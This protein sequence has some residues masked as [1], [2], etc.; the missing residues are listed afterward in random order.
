[1]LSLFGVF[2]SFFLA[3]LI[4]TKKG[5]NQADTILGVWMLIIWGHLFWLDILLFIEKRI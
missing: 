3:Q 5:R 4:F 1:M 2:T